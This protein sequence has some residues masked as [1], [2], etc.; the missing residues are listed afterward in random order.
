MKKTGLILTTV[1]VAGLA[2]GLYLFVKSRDFSQSGAGS[3]GAE[4]SK[5]PVNGGEIVATYRS[6]PSSFN[7]L[8]SV[9][10]ADDLV[11]RMV[12]DTLLRVDRRTGQ[13]EPRLATQW[14]SSADGLT[15]TLTLRDNVL[16]SD[17][18]PFSSAD[19]LFSFR[20]LYDPVVNSQV[21][22]S[23][24]INGKP[25]T[26]RALDTR[27]V[28]V[29]F[30]SAYAPGI[31]LLEALPILPAHKLRAALDA[32]TFQKSWSLATPVAEIVGLGP[33][34]IES[35]TQGDRL[36]FK[37]NPHFWKHD[38]AGRAMPYLDRIQLQITP[39]QDTETVR[40]QGGAVDLTTDK[41]R[42]EDFAALQ[43]LSQQGR[44]V[45]HDAGV[46][47]SPDML[48]F[49]LDPASTSAHERPWLQR[50]EFRQALSQAVDR[51]AIV[52]TV[53]LGEAVAVAGPITPG[54]A[55]WYVPDL[56]STSFDLEAAKRTLDALGLVDRNG[57]GVRD[58]ASGRT[59]SFTI[60]TQK[61]NS[62]RERTSSMIQEQLLHAG[63]QVEVLPMEERAMQAQFGAGTY[64]AML[65]G[66]EFDSFDPARNLEF[67]LSSGSF[68]VWH[69]GEKAPATPWEAELDLLMTRQSTTSDQATRKKL[70]A[71]AQKVLAAHS[72]VL[73]F[74]APKVV[75]ASSSR[76]GGVEASVLAPNV[77]WNAE[78][79]Y[80]KPGAADA[81]R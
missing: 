6:E 2:T 46:S 50:D 25:L 3:A 20:A 57:D 19:V 16:F 74:A 7:R 73:Y 23:L 36:I 59:A 56:V 33:F 69:L 9:R 48:W 79:L 38:A 40:L 10:L 18:Q 15:W 76:L 47:I 24:L 22:S 60:L 70:F 49:N 52:N 81:R 8:V 58:D 75:V 11:A 62:I 37:R 67:W 51:S 14:A 66:F 31:S 12:H 71:D 32:G 68:H 41:I 21:A 43:S 39:S 80:I 5:T 53:F 78:A 29:Q 45:L 54:H 55:D 44:I 13:L 1:A 72:P 35:Y 64:E 77:L 61:G 63:L 34:V 26:V 4:T 42:V 27:T 17:G 28:T 65:Y 30:P